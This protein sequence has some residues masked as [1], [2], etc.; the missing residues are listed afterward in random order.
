MGTINIERLIEIHKE[1]NVHR[2]C[3]LNIT[4]CFSRVIP[5]VFAV[6]GHICINIMIKTRG[7]MSIS[8]AWSDP[9]L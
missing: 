6:I 5:L 7:A 1:A 9:V 4:F 8:T 2:I 3:V